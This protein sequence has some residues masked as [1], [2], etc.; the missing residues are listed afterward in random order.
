MSAAASAGDAMS[1]DEVRARAEE[2]RARRIAFVAATVVRAE[3]PTSAKAGDSAVILGDGTVIGFVGGQCAEASVAVQA[4]EALDSGEPR[5]L[6]VSPDEAASAVPGAVNVHNPCLSGGTLEIFL[7]PFL[8]P[9]LLAVHGSGPIAQALRDLAPHAGWE[10]AGE[11]AASQ[12]TADAV[13]VASHGRDEERVLNAALDAGAGYIGLVASPRRGAAVIAGLERPADHDRIHTPAGI[14]IGAR[15]PG[16]VAVSILAEI[17]ATRPRSAPPRSPQ[18]LPAATA[19]TATD[20]VCS[21]TVV[22]SEPTLHADHAGQRYWFCG[23]GCR[24]AFVASP[25]TFLS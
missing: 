19:A 23:S 15:T 4:L 20:P 21:M 5:L 9:P 1:P 24:D 16:E 11:E 6:H 25:G 8:P 22:A 13:V 10:I 14:D 3:R 2:L 17:V 18:H 12:A 7:Q